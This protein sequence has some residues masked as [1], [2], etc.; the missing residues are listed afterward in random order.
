MKYIIILV[1]IISSFISH[2]Q[3]CTSDHAHA[4]KSKANPLF[5]TNRVQLN[6]AIEKA[7]SDNTKELRGDT[8]I[9]PIVFHIFHNGDPLGTQEN[10][11]DELIFAQLE[12]L[13]NDYNRLNG[14]ASM[15]PDAFAGVAV[16]TNIE[17]CLATIDPNGAPTDGINRFNI[18]D[19]PSIDE[20][21]CWTID[22][23]DENFV[24]PVI[25]DRDFY[26]NVFSILSIDND[27][28]GTCDFFASLGFAQFP[29]GSAETDA[30]VVSFFTMGSELM[31]NPLI[32]D[33][34]GRTLTHEVGHWLNLDHPWGSGAGSCTMDDGIADTPNQEG[35]VFGCGSFP[36]FD[37][38]SSSGDGIMFSNFMQSFDDECM[39]MFSQGQSERMRTTI[40]L[41]RPTL[42]TSIC[43]LRTLSIAAFRDLQA[44]Q[45]KDDILVEWI[46]DDVDEQSTVYLEHSTDLNTFSDLYEV[47]YGPDNNIN[48]YTYTHRNPISGIH[49]YRLRF[50]DIQNVIT[51]SDVVSAQIIKDD[52]IVIN[53]PVVNILKISLPASISIASY[54]I[55]STDGRLINQGQNIESQHS[56]DVSA[57]QNGVYIIRLNTGQGSILRQWIKL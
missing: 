12:Q 23:I 32:P 17:F 44:K 8:I 9:I 50:Q 36:M 1:L 53:N 51:Y 31:P 34:I 4:V 28:N 29:G 13:N 6:K 56:I 45:E 25:W 26:L 24:R 38:C 7:I 22:Y 43:D 47:M 21:D 37:N 19:I 46:I 27:A 49:Y 52:H 48:N 54:D 35:I 10:V 39:N 55:I 57:Y 40:E 20:S 30:V 3:V 2:G 41:A 15:T 42:L 5:Q 14:D 16:D 33:F 11:T 18:N